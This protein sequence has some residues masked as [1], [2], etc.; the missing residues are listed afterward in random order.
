MSR[1]DFPGGPCYDEAGESGE[2]HRPPVSE[3]SLQVG[4]LIA[5]LSLMT[6]QII[7]P[8]AAT[9]SSEEAIFN[10][11]VPIRAA[12]EKLRLRL[13]DLTGRNRLINFRHSPGK[14]LQFVHSTMD[15]VFRR[16]TGET[17]GKVTIAPLP[18]PPKSEWIIEAGRA[19]RPDPKNF[20]VTQGIDASYDLAP[21]SGRQVIAG[22]SGNQL[23]TL[24]YAEDLGRHCRKLDRDARL[25]IEET[26]ANMLFLVFGFLEYAEM[27]GGDKVYRAPLLCVPV[28]I[29][30]LESGPYTTFQLAWT[31]EELTDNLSLREKIKRDFGLTL[32]EY[33]E[34]AE[35]SSIDKYLDQVSDAIEDQ[36]NWRVR[37][38]MT[39]TLLSFANML[40]VRDLDPER[41]PKKGRMNVSAL[42]SHPVVRQVI[43]GRP[44]ADQLIYAEEYS[45]DDHPQRD[46]PL[47]FDADSSQ[48]SALI[49]VLEGNN[50]VIEGPPGTGKSQ[51]I[52][53][54]IA[55]AIQSGKKI[56]FV[57]EK[58][59]ALEV[60]KSRLTLAGLDDFVL[61]LHSNKTN[62]KRVLESLE[63][64]IKL[65][66]SHDPELANKLEQL[67]EKRRELKKYADLLNSKEGNAQELTLHQVIWRAERYRI[68]CGEDAVAAQKITIAGADGMGRPKFA[69]LRDSIA[70]LGDQFQAVERFGPD[71]PLW[72]FFPSELGPQDDLPIRNVLYKFAERFEAFEC[73]VASTSDLVGEEL[74]LGKDEV[75]TLMNVLASLLPADAQVD[76]E[77]LPRL[78]PSSDP[79]GLNSA[80]VLTALRAAVERLGQ[81][82]AE[83]TSQLLS[84]GAPS[85]AT[86]N[87]ATTLLSHLEGAGLHD[88]NGDRLRTLSGVLRANCSDATALLDQI[89]AAAV[90]SK[91]EFNRSRSSAHRLRVILASTA[92]A[93]LEHF[94]LRHTALAD[95]SASKALKGA[96]AELR[97]IQRERQQ[98]NA[99][100]YF[101]QCPNDADLRNAIA[102]L[103]EGDAWYRVFQ[104]PWRRAI[105]LHRGLARHKSRMPASERLEMLERV[106]SHR[107]RTVAWQSNKDLQ[108]L[109]GQRFDGEQSPLSG[110]DA[111]ASWIDRMRDAL[112][113]AGIG[114]DIFDPTTV[115]RARVK[116]LAA[117]LARIPE[118]FD[119]LQAIDKVIRAAVP[120]RHHA[121]IHAL[122]AGD[123]PKAIS[124]LNALAQVVERGAEVVAS[125]V[126]PGVS[127]LRGIKALVTATKAHELEANIRSNESFHSVL[128]ERFAGRD[129]DLHRAFTAHEFGRQVRAAHLPP[130][131]EGALLSA[132][133]AIKHA[134]L[135]NLT[136][137]MGEGWQALAEFTEEMRRFGLFDPAKWAGTQPGV[138]HGE[139][140]HGL[141]T[142]TRAAIENLDRL[143]PWVQY[144]GA[145]NQ[146]IDNDLQELVVLLE[147]KQTT[148]SRLGDLFSYRFFASVAQ[149]AFR[150][151]GALRQFTSIRHS[152]IRRGFADLDREVIRLRGHQVARDSKSDAR[153]PAGNFGSRVDDKTEMELVHHLLPQQRPR[154]PV[155]KLLRKAGRAIQELKPC[156][157]MGPQAVAQFLEPG[158]LE[159]DI[160]VMDEASQLKPEEA[161]GAVARGTQLVVVGDPKQLPPTTF[162][163]RM[164]QPDDEEQTATTDAESILDVCASHFRP[165]RSLRWH[166]RSQHESLI[167]FSN[168]FFYQGKLVVF[169]SPYP[170]GRALGVHYSFVADGRY[171]NQINQP[172]ARRIV[173]AVV[174]H[175]TTRPEQS[176]GV[177]TLNIKQREL[178][179]EM[180]E[181]KLRQMPEATAF[182]ER[183]EAERMGLFVKNLENVQGDERD[184]IIVGTTFGKSAGT[185]AVR[186]NFGPISREGGWRRLNVLF[187]R[188]R[189][190]LTVYSSMRSD[191]IIVDRSTPQGTV[192][193]RNYL[194][195]A[196]TGI[197]PIET[198]TG[199]E[200]ESDF[201]VAVIEALK[202]KGYECTPQLGVAGFRIDIG[203]RHPHAR[204]G[205]LAAIE[206]DGA[207]YHTGV[208]VRDR[209]R[210][211]QDILESLGWR[212]RIWRIWS[213]DWFRSP[214]T[215]TQRMIQFL[216]GLKSEPVTPEFEPETQS[217][218]T[219]E[220]RDPIDEQLPTTPD[221]FTDQGSSDLEIQVG[222]LVTYAAVDSTDAPLTVRITSHQTDLS[223]GLIAEATPLASILIGATA[224]DTVVL[225]VPGKSPQSFSILSIK[226]GNSI[227]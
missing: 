136:E 102:V 28:A 74:N 150:K 159:F 203:V 197:L 36:L 215:E 142:R 217:H 220:R 2:E 55:S 69:A 162:F 224:G 79:A 31:G 117:T 4:A 99:E 161:I 194:E 1:G 26:G 12:L 93:P 223:Q 152:S 181:D 210:I 24:F 190:S 18:E 204:S 111:V 119:A 156:F 13:L 113:T 89:E 84:A 53:N 37:R 134:D 135:L 157:M 191:D 27:P 155:R 47:V 192:A 52:T 29:S 41:W 87:E 82:E 123:W 219:V 201:E 88:S 173:E 91:L 94:E 199:L 112:D 42:M 3:Q 171:E 216:D 76:F 77:L 138:G 85:A 45:I 179:S 8:T 154:V 165:V 35:S 14:S 187:T 23:K 144:V 153:P 11:T 218:D 148:W 104:A 19:I 177:V 83:V 196:S 137:Q 110:L 21:N 125:N 141:A 72:G 10:G 166:Y 175:I 225:R 40:L 131:V 101:D 34:E 114:P 97:A 209:D 57:A 185:T 186:Q 49:D 59:A 48:H 54:L 140:V 17:Q 143:L 120:D 164:G 92:E 50:R 43:E 121:A 212:G 169:P 149:V 22:T 100:V 168:H 180:L 15:G 90:A 127:A 145:R 211:R 105:A 163:S 39:L 25:A 107:A 124:A 71:H 116:L 106:S 158:Y 61:E 38:G 66:L 221:L 60:V 147:A 115:D 184:C 129:T 51:T 7:E 81:M 170:K 213:A 33:D 67:E 207:T 9:T 226:R 176:L 6:D 95:P 80:K 198:D 78:F 109:C 172:E 128:G 195:Y 200:P 132:A 20:A 182:K 126:K 64:R 46:L 205:Y 122:D 214:A 206:C 65:R 160:V 62:K 70:Y 63:R 44:A 208:S 167:A 86:V 139:Y 193:L 189:R 68:R 227:N 202:A 130:S 178:I 56:L 98:L 151:H 75:S 73:A 32:P 16:L 183:W 5:K 103:R 58:L 118:L 30:K 108:R 146:V 96:V 222:D 133:G 188:A 174:D